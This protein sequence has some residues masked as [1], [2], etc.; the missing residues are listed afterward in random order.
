M[1]LVRLIYTSRVT[2]DN[3]AFGPNDIDDILQTSKR[4]NK[5]SHITGL[6]CF[7]RKYFLQCIEGSRE[8]VNRTYNKILQDKRHHDVIMLGYEEIN[9]RSFND[10]D[11]GF[12]AESSFTKEMITRFTPTSDFDP[13]NMN[14]RSALLM[15]ES[16]KGIIE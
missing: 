5:K 14:A 12:I 3:N 9:E 10:W 7:N 13:Y 6:L 15:L 4:N 11:M 1:Y 16:L 8:Q 2:R